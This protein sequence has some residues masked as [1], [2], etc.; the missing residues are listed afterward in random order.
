MQQG[1]LIRSARKRGPDV[2]QFR[3]ADRG[4]YGKRIYRKRVIGTACQYADADSARRAVTGLLREINANVFQRCHLPMTIAE[5]CD[6]FVQRELTKDNSWRSYSTKKAYKACLNR[7]VIP[8]WGSVRLSE[9]RTT[10]VELWLRSLP[11]AKSSCE[12]TR[13]ILSV[14]FNHACRHELFDRNPIRLVRQS[15]KRRTTPSVLTPAEIKALIH[16]LGLRERT[17]VLL[18]ASTGLRQSELFGLKWGDI[19]FAQGTMNVTRSIV[20]GVV[21]PC[22]TE[23]SQKPVPVH[24][25]VLEA[26]SE[27]RGVCLYNKLGDWVFASKR[28]HG[29]K[30]IWGQAILRKYIRPVAKRVGIQKRF[31][32]HTFRH[33]YSTLLRSVGTE[34]KVMQEL[35]RHSSLRSTLDVYTQAISPAKHAAQAAVL[36]L[37]FTAETNT[38]ESSVNAA[39]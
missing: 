33:T 11:L 12:K 13:G 21:G 16:G 36:A 20:Y 5:V 35:L 37:V 10:E 6:H 7:W 2:W 38:T 9:V 1:S 17:L 32:W 22:K 34:F 39:S 27:W 31:G 25:T 28:H 14:L 15:A 26:L 19:N 29:R 8:H 24:L 30:P 18:A 4:P 3:W 23:S